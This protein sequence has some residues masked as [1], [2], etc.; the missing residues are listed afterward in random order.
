MG[1]DLETARVNACETSFSRGPRHQLRQ[2]WESEWLE[3][4]IPVYEWTRR[5]HLQQSGFKT[6][7]KNEHCEKSIDKVDELFMEIIGEN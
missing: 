2:V 7:S 1:P 6:E 3:H 5:Q 4:A